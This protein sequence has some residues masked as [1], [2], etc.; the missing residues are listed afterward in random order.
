MKI[1]TL[2][3]S[4]L[5]VYNF[6]YL[7][8][9]VII[10]DQF[11]NILSWNKK[12]EEIFGYTKEEMV[13]RDIAILFD[14]DI[15]KIYDS[16]LT[17]KTCVLPSKTSSNDDI[18]V[19]LASKSFEKHKKIIISIRDVTKHQDVIK[20]L[21]VEYETAKKINNNKSRFLVGLSSDLKTPI[22]SLIGFSQGLLD[23]VC[24]EL[25]EK[26]AKYVSIISKNSNNLLELVDNLLDLSAIEIGNI[27]YNYRVFDLMK[28]INTISAKV[29]HLAEAKGLRLEVDLNDLVKKNVYSDENILTKI[30]LNILENA[31]KFTEIGSVRLKV[32]HPDEE[33]FK[34]Q[35]IPMPDEFND[36]TYLLFQITDT[37]IG[38]TEDEKSIIFDEYSQTDRTIARKY[39]G[40]GLKLA[41][42]RKMLSELDGYIWVESEQ[43]QGSTFSFIIPIEKPQD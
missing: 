15:D 19:E 40:T 3:R 33:T 20:K 9:G 43:G 32:L 7:P 21:L 14:Q 18:F 38:L 36:K 13:G 35:C 25:T 6:N 34:T 4:F 37:G 16:L 30:L 8:D 27:D 42:A 39:G 26:Q 29:Q 22:H 12:A 28:T 23:G 10:I 11:N 24:G 5:P 1:K 31:V 2:I 17:K 41:L